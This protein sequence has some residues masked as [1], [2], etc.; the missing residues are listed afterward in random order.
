MTTLSDLEKKLKSL[1]GASAKF[2]PGRIAQVN[3]YYEAYL[4]AEMVDVA[5]NN[6]WTVSYSH[7][8]P[9]D[10]QFKFRMGPGLLTSATEFTHANLTNVNGLAGELHLGLRVEGESGVLHEFDLVALRE[11]EAIF[12]RIAGRQP[13]QF[14]VRLHVEAKFHTNDLSLGV[15]RGIVGLQADCPSIH[16]FLVS[17]GKGSPMLRKL[18]K[19][20]GATY[21]HNAVPN[22]TGAPYLRNC[23]EAALAAWK[24]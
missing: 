23:F 14:V 12:D 3:D 1:L 6:S 24:P 18:L 15:A 10:D 21:V 17:R 19:Y 13:S 7:A 9:A 20:H 11:H 4:W 16:G 5:R 22:G 8:G 2:Y